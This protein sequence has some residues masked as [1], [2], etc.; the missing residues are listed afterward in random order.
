MNPA[1]GN[2]TPSTANATT[3]DIVGVLMV[4]SEDSQEIA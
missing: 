4:P 1:Q 3:F 2:N